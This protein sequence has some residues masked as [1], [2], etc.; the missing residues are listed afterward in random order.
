LGKIKDSKVYAFE[1]PKKQKAQTRAQSEPRKRHLRSAEWSA[2]ENKGL[3]DLLKKGPE[4]DCFGRKRSKNPPCKKPGEE[5]RRRSIKGR[6]LLGPK[7][8][9]LKYTIAKKAKKAP[10]LP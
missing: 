4:D 1:N 5:E 8:R 6:A 7:R 9:G 10:V 2:D 3:W